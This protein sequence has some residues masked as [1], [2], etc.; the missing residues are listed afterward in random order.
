MSLRRKLLIGAMIS[1]APAAMVMAQQSATSPDMP[2][3]STSPAAASSP[4]QQDATSTYA[5]QAPASDN[6]T[7]PSAA[8][9][10][11]QQQAVRTASK[12]AMKDCIAREKTDNSGMSTA[13]ARKACKTQLKGTG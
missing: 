4:S 8:S 3:S 1:M 5:P 9:S 12:A 7:N 11:S 6:S 13:D 10:P 2:P